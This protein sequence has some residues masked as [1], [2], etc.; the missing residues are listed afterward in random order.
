MTSTTDGLGRARVGGGLKRELGS[1]LKWTEG[2]PQSGWIEGSF[3]PPLQGSV[4]EGLTSQGLHPGL[5][6]GPALRAWRF[7]V[8]LALGLSLALVLWTYW[9]RK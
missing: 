3:G 4:A 9:P 1:P 5:L 6:F 7:P 2:R 8:H